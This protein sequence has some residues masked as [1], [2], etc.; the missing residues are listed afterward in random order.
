MLCVLGPFT[1]S[2]TRKFYLALMPPIVQAQNFLS[3]SIPDMS[4]LPGL[5][6]M[7]LGGNQLKNQLPLFWASSLN[8]EYISAQNNL[9]T[10][11]VPITQ[12]P[13]RLRGEQC[14]GP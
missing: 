3:G 14:F 5:V 7:D 12:I 6:L 9:L 2:H 13:S 4:R 10:G 1:M 11:S 8:L